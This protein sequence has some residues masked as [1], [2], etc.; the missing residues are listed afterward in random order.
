MITRYTT[1]GMRP[2]WLEKNSF[3]IWLDV[4]IAACVAWNKHGVIP[5]NELQKIKKAK[6][7]LDSYNKWFAETKHH[8]FLLQDR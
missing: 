2:I 7:S 1:E 6:F 3:D 4:E 5:D 8:L